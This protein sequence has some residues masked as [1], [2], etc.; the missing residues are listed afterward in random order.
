MDELKLRHK[1]L[2][3]TL[4]EEQFKTLSEL[5][6]VLILPQADLDQIIA[7]MKG[8]TT[9]LNKKSS[10]QYKWIR[11]YRVLSIGGQD[12]LCLKSNIDALTIDGVV[13]F[14]KVLRICSQENL[15]DVLHHAHVEALGHAGGLRVYKYLQSKY[16]NI[17]RDWCLSFCQSCPA[18]CLNKRVA[19]KAESVM[20]ILSSSFNSRGQVDLIDMQSNPIGG[21]KWLLNYQDHLTEFLYLRPMPQKTGA[22]VADVLLSIFQIQGCPLILQSDNGKEFVN[23][24]ITALAAMWPNNKI[25]HGRARHPQSQGSGCRTE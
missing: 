4:S 9:N 3:K 25:L 12:I 10:L 13:D 8:Y 23:H 15:F 14:E 21:M 2:F 11:T 1:A 20:P 19:G 17:S 16:V 18:C 5:N 22:C 6:R 7:F 24:V